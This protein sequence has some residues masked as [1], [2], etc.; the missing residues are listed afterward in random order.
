MYA[1]HRVVNFKRSQ[2]LAELEYV[3]DKCSCCAK[4]DDLVLCHSDVW[5]P[6]TIY[7][8]EKGKYGILP[9][10]LYMYMRF[11]DIPFAEAISNLI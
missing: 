3:K 7:D 2:L 11:P 8:R 4:H 9:C 1:L 10:Q 6:N 5:Y